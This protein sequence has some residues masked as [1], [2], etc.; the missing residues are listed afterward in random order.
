MYIDLIDFHCIQIYH[1]SH[2]DRFGSPRCI[3]P[4]GMRIH[5]IIAS[6]TRQIK[7]RNIYSLSC[8]TI[9]VASSTVLY[10]CISEC[11]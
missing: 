9:S 7:C 5:K 2:R 3:N 8:F 4:V 1:I 6:S 10:S 11:A